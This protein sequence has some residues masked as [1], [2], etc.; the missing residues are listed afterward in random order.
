[1]AAPLSDW[2]TTSWTAVGGVVVSAVLIYATLILFTRLA[3]LRSFSKM[4][5]FDFAMTVAIGSILA[6]SILTDSP[7]L[8]QAIV[9]LGAIYALQIGAA[10][11]RK[12]FGWFSRLIDNEPLI[13]MTRDGMVRANLKK[14]RVTEHDI[15]AKL[16]EANVLT[17]AEVRAVV[18]ESTGDISVL[19]GPADGETLEACLLTGVRDAE[20]VE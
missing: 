5:G 13:L 7:P 8:L 17:I 19:H 9:G 3:G 2:I 4:S 15:W 14:A 18:F 11:L 16:R 12:R 1:M 10:A 20:R 6:T